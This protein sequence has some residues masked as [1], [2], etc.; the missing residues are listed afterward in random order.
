MKIRLKTRQKEIQEKVAKKRIEKEKKEYINSF[1]KSERKKVEELLNSMEFNHRSQNK[2][3]ILS[4][5]AIGAFFMMYS[6][7]FLTWNILTQI[8]VGSAFALFAYFF[9]RMVVSAWRGDRCKRNIAFIRRK[10]KGEN[11]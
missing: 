10:Q 8:A 6:Y 9:S 2:Y 7:G 11:L 5:L 3:G 4:L 1:S